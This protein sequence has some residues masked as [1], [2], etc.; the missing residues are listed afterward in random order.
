MSGVGILRLA[1]LAQDDG[2]DKRQKQEQIPC[3]NDKEVRRGFPSGMTKK[4][5]GCKRGKEE[6]EIHG[7][8]G[9]G[10]CGVRF[11]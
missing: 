5:A 3:G 10:F 7:D 2:K 8:V 1:M 6:S 9:S 11:D 4:K